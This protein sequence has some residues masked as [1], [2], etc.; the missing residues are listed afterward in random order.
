MNIRVIFLLTVLM[1]F[2]VGCGAFSFL[3]SG[4]ITL[5]QAY[6]NNQVEIIQNTAAG[7][8]PH[9]VTIK[10]NGTKPV[11]VEKGTILKSKESQ[12]LVI[13]DD[14]KISLN[15]NDTV[16]AYCI[17]PDEKA[18]PGKTLTPSGTVSSQIKQIIDTSNPSDLQNATKSQ[19]QIWIIVGKGAVDPYTGEASA[20]VQ[21]Q[22]IKYYQLQEKLNTAKNDVMTIFNLN[23]ET[24]QNL[25]ST[26]ES[27]SSVNTW[28]S[29]IR[30]WIRNNFKI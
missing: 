15:A 16:R 21:N 14:K 9:N 2:A 8:V 6:D 1:V 28:L 22:K 24:I 17:E 4:G 7:T 23:N 18:V 27:S 29:D 5:G 10:N 20:L 26:S 12:D 11:V 25:S 30:Q 13:I 3:S 19:L